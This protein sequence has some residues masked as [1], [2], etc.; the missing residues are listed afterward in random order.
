M[1]PTTTAK[2]YTIA[3][4][5]SSNFAEYELT[6]AHGCVCAKIDVEMWDSGPNG[7]RPLARH[8]IS[9]LQSLLPERAEVVREGQCEEETAP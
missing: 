7:F 6:N 4:R 8:C 3:V 5:R 2:G 9:A 1:K